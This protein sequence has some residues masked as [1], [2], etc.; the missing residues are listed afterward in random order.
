VAVLPLTGDLDE[1]KD[2]L[3]GKAFSLVQMLRLGINVPPAFCITTDECG[4]YYEAGE[5][6]PADVIDALPGAMKHL[7]EITGRTFTKD[8]LVSVRSGAPTSMPGMMDTVL[9]LGVVPGGSYP[10]ADI[11]SR[12]EEMYAKVVGSEPPADPWKQLH[13]AI[14]AVFAS[15]NSKRAI[16]YRNNRGL[17]DT[18]GTAVTVQAMVFGNADPERS[19]T[20]V[21]FSRNPMNGDNHVFGEWLAGGQGEDVVS[22]SHDPEPLSALESAYPDLHGELMDVTGRLE[23]EYRD[24]MDIEFTVESGRLWLLQARAGKRTPA[25]A[26]RLAVLL[27]NEGI[28]TSSEALD[29]VTLDQVKALMRDHVNPDARAAATVLATGKPACPGLVTGTIVTD[30][31]DAEDRATD[32][33]NI[34]LARPVTTPDDMHA[35]AVVK[36][37]A[38]EVGGATS[39]AAVVSRELGVACIVG[40]G[41][42][43]L[44][45]LDGTVVTL[46]ADNGELLAGELPTVKPDEEHDPDLQQLAEWARAEEGAEQD[47]ALP[48]L[49]AARARLT[50]SA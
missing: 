47:V 4:R 5:Q 44:G 35:M 6:I 31:D 13:G 9:N 23:R 33:E 8:L 25:A 42:G 39:H 29:R 7:E 40:V 17:P 21:L 24:M 49:L 18:G 27:A 30:V 45:P 11:P 36:G 28:I 22:G 20:G 10:A 34:I 19:G 48:Q 38:T 37:I 16:A 50:A 43:V 3:G 41:Q 14:A 26:V 12:F 46:D 32:G 1:G 2:V 15:W